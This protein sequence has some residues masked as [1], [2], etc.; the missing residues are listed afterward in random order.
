VTIQSGETDASVLYTLDGTSPSP[1]NGTI[2]T[3]PLK[4]TESAQLRAVTY[5]PCQP[6]S[7]VAEADFQFFG[8][9]L[10]KTGDITLSGNDE[11]VIEDTLFLHEGNIT[12]TDNARLVIRNSFVTHV[13]DFGFQYGVSA[14]GNSSITLENSSIG[15]NCTGSFNYSF[16]DS[17]ALHADHVDV[18]TGNCNTWFFMGGDSK[19]DI[20]NWDYFGGTVCNDLAVA[21][22]D[23]EKMEVELCLPGGATVDMTLPTTVDRYSYG[24]YPAKG[25]DF[26]L[27]MTNSTVEGWGI[28]VLPG[29]HITIRDA[30]AI[31]I[32]VIVGL[33]WQDVTAKLDG[34]ET[35][36]YSFNRWNIGPDATLTLINTSVYG[37]EPNVFA[38]N[39]LIIR[40]S[41]YT[42]STVNSGDGLYE[43]SDSTVNIL[44][45][46]ERVTMT[47]TN[48]VITGDVIANDDSVIILIDCEVRGADFG[49]GL[50]GGNVFARGNGKVILR[51][52]SVGGRTETQDDATITSE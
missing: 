31:T 15:S 10:E 9:L 4:L 39:T 3:A 33:P 49:D 30:D 34:L 50:T 18:G 12:L 13:K 8:H 14:S 36:Y 48:T 11:M 25:V 6:V 16:T 2:Y 47:V 17:A 42:A 7:E 22:S 21:I 44:S 29:A 41:N 27:E 19:I 1:Q 45:A 26:S 40:N 24:P 32:G 5:R 52:T 46:A 35:G 20:A 38:D 37:W 43:I 23:S 28:N 51:N